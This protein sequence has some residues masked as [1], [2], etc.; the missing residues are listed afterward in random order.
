MTW[1]LIFTG[2]GGQGVISAGILI[3]EAAVID[4]G[5]YAVQSQSYGAEMRGG[6]SRSDVTISDDPIIYPK[7]DQAHILV[8]LHRK[9]LTAHQNTLRPGGILITDADESPITTPID[10]RQYVLPLA[11]T[12]RERF[13]STRTANMCA[14]GAVVEIS[15]VVTEQGILRAIARRYG[16]SS[17]ATETNNA[18]FEIGRDLARN[19]GRSLAQHDSV[20][21]RGHHATS[22]RI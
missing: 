5:R 11:A 14:L 17:K 10:C 16:E 8:S 3:S 13:G 6:L 2:V 19:A 18:A 22:V 9:G 7:V 1:K 20:Q 4:E 21:E 15:S 12:V